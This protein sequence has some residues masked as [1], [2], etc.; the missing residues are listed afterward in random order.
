MLPTALHDRPMRALALYLMES[1]NR[2]IWA[3][4]DAAG[5]PRQDAIRDAVPYRPDLL[6]TKTFPLLSVYRTGC[7]DVV[8]G[9]WRAELR[10]QMQMATARAGDQ[11]DFL[12]WVHQAIARAME[13]YQ[14]EEQPCVMVDVGSMRSEVGYLTLSRGTAQTALSFPTVQFTF[15]FI[16]LE[17]V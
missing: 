10:W 3:V 17:A 9:R 6:S 11:Q 2:E 1:V 13:R 4:F 15:E 14:D 12:L 16:D 7:S 8:G 5:E